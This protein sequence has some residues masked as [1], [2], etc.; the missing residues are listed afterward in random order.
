MTQEGTMQSLNTS[1]LKHLP[2]SPFHASVVF[3]AYKTFMLKQ[4]DA[5]KPRILL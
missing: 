4:H 3:L 1:R 5:E 2:F